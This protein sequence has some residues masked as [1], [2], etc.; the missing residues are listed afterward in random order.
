MI[1][2]VPLH[3][4]PNVAIDKIGTRH[5]L[6]LFLPAKYKAGGDEYALTREQLVI[7]YNSCVRVAVLRVNQTIK[8]IGLSPTRMHIRSTRTYAIGYTSTPLI[9]HHLGSKTLGQCYLKRLGS[10]LGVAEPT[11]STNSEAK[12]AQQHTRPLK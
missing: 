5:I 7:L 2:Q 3:L 10:T 11:S 6:R 4:I 1:G 9:F 8:H 12:K